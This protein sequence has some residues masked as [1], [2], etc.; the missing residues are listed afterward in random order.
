MQNAIRS[1][2]WNDRYLPFGG[3]S[4]KIVQRQLEG[5]IAVMVAIA[6]F[7]AGVTLF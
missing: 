2:Y 4:R 7:A 6:I 3:E 1:A 5:A